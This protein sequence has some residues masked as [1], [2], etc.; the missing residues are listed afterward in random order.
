MLQLSLCCLSAAVHITAGRGAFRKASRRMNISPATIWLA[1][2]LFVASGIS[3][4]TGLAFPTVATPL[5]LLAFDPIRTVALTALCSVSGQVVSIVSLRN[6]VAYAVRWPLVLPA[7]AGVPI[8]LALLEVIDK[9]VFG[10]IA[11]TIIAGSSIWWLCKPDLRLPATH[12]LIE[13]FAGLAGGLSGGLVGVSA[14]IPA[15]WCVGSGL[16]MQRQRAILQPFILIV[17]LVSAALLW[18]HRFVDSS[19]LRNYLV[20]IVPVISGS[21]LGAR[22]SRA[23]THETFVRIA[24]ALTVLSGL[25]LVLR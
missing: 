15:I 18:R 12:P 5:L 4:M 1:C 3:G 22:V 2:G 8:G 20:L 11:G 16:T 19:V 25:S 9:H 24:M 10:L 23:L 14:A 7:I 21:W 17:Q 6:H 13:I